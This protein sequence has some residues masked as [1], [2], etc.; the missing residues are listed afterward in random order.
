M[1]VSRAFPDYILDD[2]DSIDD[3]I[4]M[5]LED[6]AI[7]PDTIDGDDEAASL[8]W[9]EDEEGATALNGGAYRIIEIW[10]WAD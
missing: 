3:A 4:N 6:H 8:V 7:K 10:E 5:A 2:A 9:Y 1:G